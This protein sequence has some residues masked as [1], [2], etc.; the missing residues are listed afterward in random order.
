MTDDKIKK[1]IECRD[2]SFAVLDQ[3][4]QKSLKRVGASCVY[5]TVCWIE[6]WPR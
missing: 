1:A 4:R 5:L 2:R 6:T 3:R